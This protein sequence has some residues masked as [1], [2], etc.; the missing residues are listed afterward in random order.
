MRLS[1]TICCL[2]LRCN[3]NQYVKTLWWQAVRPVQWCRGHDWHPHH[4]LLNFDQVRLIAY[5]ETKER[6]THSKPWIN[7]NSLILLNTTKHLLVMNSWICVRQPP[8]IN[9][10]HQLWL[11]RTQP[12]KLHK[13]VWSNLWVAAILLIFSTQLKRNYGTIHWW[14]VDNS[15]AAVEVTVRPPAWSTRLMCRCMTSA[16]ISS[17]C[18][19]W[20]RAHLMFAWNN[21]VCIEHQQEEGI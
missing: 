2:A 17:Y 19:S 20:V 1:W 21:E 15:I 7:S 6:R 16:K 9:K 5:C 12:L 3:L 8:C 4:S 11:T 18:G 14:L 10:L 13:E